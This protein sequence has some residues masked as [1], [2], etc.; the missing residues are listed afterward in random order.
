M[1]VGNL[2]ILSCPLPLTSGKKTRAKGGVVDSEK[3][4]GGQILTFSLVHIFEIAKII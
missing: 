1:A 4:G 2:N 3:G